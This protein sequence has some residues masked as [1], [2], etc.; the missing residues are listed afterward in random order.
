M[1]AGNGITFTSELQSAVSNHPNCEDFV[2]NYREAG[3]GGG[4]G[5]KGNL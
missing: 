2:V 3:G 4:G 1:N 5:V